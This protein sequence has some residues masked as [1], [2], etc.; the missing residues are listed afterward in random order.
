MRQMLNRC[1]GVFVLLL[2]ACV[3]S[4][5]SS[6]AEP[7]S[8]PT[9]DRPAVPKV[10]STRPWTLIPTSAVKH[11]V[12]NGTSALE[13][14]SDTAATKASITTTASFSLSASR[15]AGF[16][17]IHGTLNSFLAQPSGRILQAD[18]L[19]GLPLVFTGRL[20]SGGFSLDSINGQPPRAGDC[21]NH[22]LNSLSIIRQ[23]L[24]AVPDVLTPGLTWVDSSTVSACS[25]S[26]PLQ[27]T[28][29]RA[30]TA[31][32]E[33]SVDGSPVIAID[34]IDRF[35]ASG[36]GAQGQHRVT[37]LT[38]GT[39]SAKIYVDRTSGLLNSSNVELQARVTVT[40]SGRTQIFSQIVKERTVLVD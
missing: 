5:Q 24:I 28:A 19:S 10:V 22:D 33:T 23:S 21:R 11:Y 2:T 6:P 12:S 9:N 16:T 4:T 14:Q 31:V 29:V 39:G 36:E 32:G 26:I 3:R 27:L 15:E 20:I 35:T 7:A 40:A 17:R 13:L 25:G 30:Y 34:R 37:V 8:P 1:T 18:Q 38:R